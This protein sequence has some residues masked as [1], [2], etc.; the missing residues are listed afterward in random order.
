MPLYPA[1][2]VNW[3]LRTISS[4]CG[5]AISMSSFKLIYALGLFE[6][7]L[8]SMMLKLTIQQEEIQLCASREK[9]HSTPG[10]SPKLFLRVRSFSWHYHDHQICSN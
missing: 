10:L 6:V 3:I 5:V 2:I 8:I 1:A 9:P 4:L 7:L